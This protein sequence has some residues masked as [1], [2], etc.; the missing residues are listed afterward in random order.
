LKRNEIGP[1]SRIVR[2]FLRTRYVRIVGRRLF[3]TYRAKLPNNSFMVLRSD[4][5]W[6]AATV[7]TVFLKNVYET[8]FCVNP[9]DTVIDVGA[10][11]GSFSIKAAKETGPAGTVVAVEPSS[12]NFKLLER[13]IGMNG[14][15]NVRLLNAAGGDHIGSDKLRISQR[16]GGNSFFNQGFKEV[17]V[18]QVE[19][20]TLDSV[21]ESLKLGRVDF[22]KIDVEGSE[23]NVLKGANKLLTIQHPKIAMETHPFGPSQEELINYLGNFHYNTT[24]ESSTNTGLGMLYA[25]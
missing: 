24:T 5:D 3:T 4:F 13:N 25:S 16:R 8:H 9:G 22:L 1:E 17:D 7:A 6:D 19:I 14:F 20:K 11:I 12:E 15:S 21:V 10:H 18:E 23:L 2:F